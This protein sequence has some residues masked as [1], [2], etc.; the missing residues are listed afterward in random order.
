MSSSGG[1]VVKVLFPAEQVVKMVKLDL[2]QK[3]GTARDLIA[4]KRKDVQIAKP[5]DFVLYVPAQAT[6]AGLY[7]KDS[8]VL[9]SYQIETRGL[10]FRP[11]PRW[12]S[13]TPKVDGVK[14][15]A[16]RAIEVDFAA[17]VGAV[18]AEVARA[19][20]LA[21]AESSADCEF[22]L[23]H[24]GSDAVLDGQ[25]SLLEQGVDDGARAFLRPRQQASSARPGPGRQAHPKAG[26]STLKTKT[27][28][29]T[30][31]DPNGRYGSK[32]KAAPNTDAMRQ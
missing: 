12:L 1:T 10:E 20:G 15:N 14:N 31:K 5:Q 7:L 9:G 32:K 8:D 28:H 13:V 18:C 30:K 19:F 21:P 16:E 23:H 22:A 2:G 26:W 3:A 24:F 11:K 17:P 29:K 6:A 4:S 25:L 27:K